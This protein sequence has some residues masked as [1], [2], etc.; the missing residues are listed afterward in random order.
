M[1]IRDGYQWPAG[2]APMALRSVPS[3]PLHLFISRLSGWAL[4]LGTG[5]LL[6]IMSKSLRIS[7]MQILFSFIKT[8]FSRFD[9]RQD[10]VRLWQI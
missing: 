1:H 9:N 3:G 5:G 2:L 7:R 10:D 4:S 8:V 6:F